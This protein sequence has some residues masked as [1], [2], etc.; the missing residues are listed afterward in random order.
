[1]L[2]ILEHWDTCLR[3][4]LTGCENSTRKKFVAINLTGVE[5]LMT[6]LIYDME[7][8]RLGVPFWF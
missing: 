4:L 6:A 7:I 3:E 1:M 2:G 8:Q 5:D